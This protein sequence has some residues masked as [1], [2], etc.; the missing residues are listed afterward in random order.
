ML[1]NLV[2]GRLFGSKPKKKKK[3]KKERKEWS[4]KEIRHLKRAI[5]SKKSD[6]KKMHWEDIANLVGRSKRECYDMYKKLKAD[7]GFG[8]VQNNGGGLTGDSG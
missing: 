7:L 6:N 2:A 4:E 8:L 3:K 5:K 1:S